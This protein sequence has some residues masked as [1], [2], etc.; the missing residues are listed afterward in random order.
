MQP[1]N[2]SSAP[3]P[4]APPP[5]EAPLCLRPDLADLK[6]LSDFIE[7]FGERNGFV[8]TDTNAFLLA[9]EELFANTVHHG[10]PPATVVSFALA[11]EQ[12][13]ATATYSDD[14]GAFDPTAVPAADTTL[15][16]EKRA[17]GGLGIHFIRRTMQTFAW[18]REGAR[19]VVTFSRAVGLLAAR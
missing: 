9:A 18:H 15:P 6:L 2:S 13:L 10:R 14:A 3:S 5:A 17:I 1:P 11:V 4:S 8:P 12:G 7:A 19:N 16:Q